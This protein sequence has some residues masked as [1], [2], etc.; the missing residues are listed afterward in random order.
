MNSKI[1]VILVIISL[2]SVIPTSYAQVSVADKAI[3]ELVE[4]RIDS[5]GSVQVIHVIKSAT[6]PRQVDLIPGTVSNILVTNEQ[7]EEK[8]FGEIGNSSVLIMP[9]NEDSILQYQLEDVISEI[10]S[11]WT[12]NFLYLESTNFILPQEVDLL[13][14]NERPVYLDE[15]KGITCHGCQMLL[16]YSINESRVYEN[17][18]WEDDEFLVEIRSQTGIDEFVFNQPSKSITFE[19]TGENR[20]VTTVIPLELLWEPYTAFL[21]DEKIPAQQYINNGTHVW[22]N[23]KP[24]T[25]GQVSIIGTTVVPEFPI[26]APLTIGFLIIL[27]LPF[28]KK[29]NL[30]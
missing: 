23:I 27:V 10:E 6:E 11:I 8:Q 12:W 4:V 18:K 22:V 3:Q 30:H 7:G 24:D 21:D 19:I 5:D 17:V 28:M 26:I 9:S 29:F 14:A 2:I 16:E 1:F 20:F 25:S 15:K 13:F